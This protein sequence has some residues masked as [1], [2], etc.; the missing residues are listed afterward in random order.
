MQRFQID[1][2]KYHT[3]TGHHM[4]RK[5]RKPVFGSTQ[6]QNSLRIHKSDQRLC[7]SIFGEH[8]SQACSI[9][10]STFLASL[11]SLGDCFESRFV[12][13]PKDRFCSDK[14]HT[15]LNNGVFVLITL[16][17]NHQM[18]QMLHGWIQK[19]LSEGVQL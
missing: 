17:C 5:A 18:L 14:A 7:Y 19:Y 9:Q 11:R 15:K 13:N 4:G 16:S 2:T 6:A 1:T 8:S 12:G 3:D 10:N